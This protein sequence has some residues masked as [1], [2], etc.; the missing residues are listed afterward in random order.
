MIGA[1]G[2]Q[3]LMLPIDAPET[4]GNSDATIFNR[5]RA[6]HQIRNVGFGSDVGD[7]PHWTTASASYKL[8]PNTY[9]VKYILSPIMELVNSTAML[10]QGSTPE[11]L[12][13]KAL[14]LAE[15]IAVHIGNEKPVDVQPALM[16][17][18]DVP[19]SGESVTG[20]PSGFSLLSCGRV[21]GNILWFS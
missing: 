6:T 20:C 5:A 9:P 3:S 7:P 14:L 13:A 12:D 11:S 10:M 17:R 18:F 4:V 16:R 15:A 8:N 19:F 1:A 2:G 21:R